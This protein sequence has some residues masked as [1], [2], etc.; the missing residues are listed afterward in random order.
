MNINIKDQDIYVNIIYKNNKNIYFRFDENGILIVTC[1]KKVSK[2]EIKKLIFKNEEAIYKM[3]QKSLEKKLYN[4]E[5][6]LLGKK[7]N[8]EFNDNIDNVYINGDYIYA[9]NENE[10][11]KYT[12]EEIKRIFEEEVSICKNCFNN[13]PDFKLKTRQMKTR[14]GVCNRKDNVITLNKELIKK[15]IK[16]IDYVIIH[17]MAHFYEGNHSKNFWNI[18]SLA[19]PN[20]KEAR[21]ELRK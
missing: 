7:Y 21:K 3:Y 17:E 12:E 4:S 1:S 6:H 16:L 15:D 18:V 13:L 14:W 8:V 11:N 5:Y 20:Y 10:L 2:E 9:K 19:Y